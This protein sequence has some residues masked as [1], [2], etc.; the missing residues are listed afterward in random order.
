[1]AEPE[2]AIAKLFMDCFGWRQRPK[3]E[4]NQ[5]SISEPLRDAIYRPST[6]KEM[7]AL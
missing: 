7:S 5:R 4:L 1:M 3:S 6:V 2:A